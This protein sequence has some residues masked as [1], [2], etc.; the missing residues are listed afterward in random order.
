MVAPGTTHA[1]PIIFHR[2]AVE[3]RVIEG[4]FSVPGPS[5]MWMRLRPTLI[6]DELTSGLCQL[7]AVAD[8]GSP[9]S[10]P[11]IPPVPAA[12][13]NI[14]VNVTMHRRPV[15]PWFRLD[16][17]AMVGPTGIGL[18]VTELNDQAGAVGVTTQSQIA[19]AFTPS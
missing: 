12:L 15:G 7:M 1:A 13:I 19:H 14:D 2:D 5:V 16:A 9:I 6:S 8:F 11:V 17:R 4:G 3:H 10:Q 18:A